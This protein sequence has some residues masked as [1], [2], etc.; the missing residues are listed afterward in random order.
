[1]R[2]HQEDNEAVW[3]KDLF[4]NDRLII[5]ETQSPIRRGFPGYKSRIEA[6]SSYGIDAV[7]DFQRVTCTESADMF[8]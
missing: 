4:W 8:W 5:E 6:G 3:A 7:A 1:M 2:A